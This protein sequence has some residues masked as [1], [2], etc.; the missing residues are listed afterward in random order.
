MNDKPM[1]SPY[2]PNLPGKPIPKGYLEKIKRD[3]G[4]DCVVLAVENS[5]T[6]CS[7]ICLG[8]MTQIVSTGLSERG[9]EGIGQAFIDHAPKI[10]RES[11]D[12]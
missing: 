11:K 1:L 7:D 5:Q 10:I 9:L 4:V 8:H 6:N 3:L 2:S 12:L